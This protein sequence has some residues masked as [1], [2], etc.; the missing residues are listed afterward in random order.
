MCVLCN[1]LWIEDH[2]SE[3][4]SEEQPDAVDGIM[5]L[6]VHVQRRGQRLRDRGERARLVGIV[7]GAYAIT[8][9]DWEGSS[10]ILRDPKGNSAVVHDLATVWQEAEKMIGRP[11][12]P[13]DPGFLES[14][15]ERAAMRAAA[16]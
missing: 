8:L 16:R 4:A 13:L 5:Q 15:A 9:Q 1:Q 12:D 3:V 10:Y 6:E 11:L 2:W 14:L 7:L